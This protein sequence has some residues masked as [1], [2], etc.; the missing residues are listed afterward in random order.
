MNYSIFIDRKNHILIL[1]DG[2]DV[3][4]TYPVAVGK[5]TTPTPTGS[6]FIINKAINP[7]GSFGV[8]WMGL[9]TPGIGIHGTNK[10]ESIGKSAS[11]GCIRMQNKDILELSNTVDIGTPVDII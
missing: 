8:R 5:P 7:G 1:Y 2:Y 6:F 10:P 11:N 9:D 4:K 3:V